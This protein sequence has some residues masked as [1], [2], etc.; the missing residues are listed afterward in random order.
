MKYIYLLC[1]FLVASYSN[2]NQLS[3]FCKVRGS[4]H[5]QA[6]EELI[7]DKIIDA[8]IEYTGDAI[9]DNETIH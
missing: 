8:K 3:Y 6:A 4:S 5:H 2:Q 7:A 9:D 1:L